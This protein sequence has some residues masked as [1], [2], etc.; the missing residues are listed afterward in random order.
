MGQYSVWFTV[1]NPCLGD[2]LPQ[3]PRVKQGTMGTK[4]SIHSWGMPYPMGQYF[5]EMKSHFHELNLPTPTT[6]WPCAQKAIVFTFKGRLF[7]TAESSRLRDLCWRRHP[8][9]GFLVCRR[10]RR[11]GSQGYFTTKS[12]L[13]TGVWT[14]FHLPKWVPKLP[15]RRKWKSSSSTNVRCSCSRTCWHSES[16]KQVAPYILGPGFMMASWKI[17]WRMEKSWN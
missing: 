1:I 3:I 8:L 14:C 17:F 16:R 15:D 7:L 2:E 9:V 10:M 12:S 11:Q 5:R 6:N 4:V 13:N